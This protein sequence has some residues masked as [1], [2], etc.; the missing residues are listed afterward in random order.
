V[1]IA[2]G[3]IMAEL[4]RSARIDRMVEQVALDRAAAYSPVQFL[5]D[6][7][8]GIWSELNSPGT[9]IDIYRRNVQRS[10]LDAI[11]DRLNGTVRPSAEARALLGGEL[12]ALD[13]QLQTVLPRVTD[14]ASR[15]HLQ[16]A[17]IQIERILD[18]GSTGRPAGGV[19]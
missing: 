16:D 18:P 12:R 1:R 8:R 6:L 10:Y 11:D 9:A 15:R 19:Q 2:Q 14:E 3:A 5:E 17:R 13:R 4:L 7:R